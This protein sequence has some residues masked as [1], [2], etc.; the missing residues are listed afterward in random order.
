MTKDRVIGMPALHFSSIQ[1]ISEL[2]TEKRISVRELVTAYLSRIAEVDSCEGG[3]NS[4]LEV[5]PDALHIADAMD[6]IMVKGGELPPL[7]GVPVLLKDNI[8][9]A[10]R[11]IQARVHWRWRMCMRLMTRISSHAC[12]KPG[13]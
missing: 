7:F 2:Y 6:V 5:N 1:E 13:R 11:L 10:D 3:L 12:A 8:N 4:V 9:T